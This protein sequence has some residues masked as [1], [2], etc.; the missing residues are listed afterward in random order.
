MSKY[1][2]AKTLHL[3]AQDAIRL[4]QFDVAQGFLEQSLAL[5]ES[6]EAYHDLGTVFALKNNFPQAEEAFENAVQLNIQAHA[7]LA[8]LAALVEAR[9]DKQ[10]AVG[11]FMLAIQAQPQNKGYKEQYLRLAGGVPFLQ[12]NPHAKNIIL[13]CLKTPDLDLGSAYLLW[14]SLLC[15]DPV[16]GK[17]FKAT[18]TPEGQIL[19][20]EANDF[21]ALTTLKPLLDPYFLGGLKKMVV[22]HPVFETLMTSLRSALLDDFC[23]EKPKFASQDFTAL[24]AALAQYCFN[25]EYIFA[26][27]DAEK[28][29]VETLRVQTESGDTD[30]VGALAMVACYIP[31]YSLKNARQL[32]AA[33]PLAELF[34]QQITAYFD[35]Q[36]L[37]Q[38]ILPVT[39]IDDKISLLVQEQYED[40]PYPRWV[41]PVRRA[42]DA[43]IEADFASKNID[44]L[45]AGC[46]TGL[47]AIEIALAL[48]SAKVLAVDLSLSSLSYALKK[49]QELGIHNI[50]FRQGDILRLNELTQKFAYILCGGVLHHLENPLAGW[51]V[52]TSLLAEGGI[53]RIALYSKVA[54]QSIAEI[55]TA[56][57]QGNYPSTAKGMRRFRAE[58]AKLLSPAA[59]HFIT[60]SSDNYIMSMYRDLLFHVQEHRFDLPEIAAALDALH[61][62]FA[63]FQITDQTIASRYHAEY[64]A[65]TGF[66]SLDTMHAFEQQHPDS[67]LGM[68][69]FWCRKK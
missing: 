16:L 51:R 38:T 18:V 1:K 34:A 27:G 45:V 60:Y 66:T 31:L 46:G 32:V 24:T 57:Q 29:K 56:I 21:F 23:A 48:P 11:L 9:G 39:S 4:M 5:K 25:T 62:D 6:T 59:L 44:I 13:E 12:F 55:H 67:F 40:F 8:C 64:P 19:L 42:P 36:A 52:L 22:Y 14:F 10:T 15:L 61:L 63:K 35:L 7:S 65:D 33:K 54:R 53:M 37:R 30:S 68:Y 50:T 3:Q 20:P 58:C 47:E 41:H 28:N 2:A 17:V 69:K 26:Y 43:D 49:S